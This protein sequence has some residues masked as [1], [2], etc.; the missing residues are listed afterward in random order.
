MKSESIIF[1]FFGRVFRYTI[2]IRETAKRKG[3]PM[4]NATFDFPLKAYVDGAWVDGG[5]GYGFVIL[6]RSSIIAE[7]SES[8][9]KGPWADSRQVGGEL[10]A[11]MAVL[12][13]CEE[14]SVPEIT[15]FYDYEGIRSWA[16]GE[17]K[18]NKEITRTYVGE[19]RRCS[20]KVRW[21]KVKSHS[22]DRYN[23]RVDR[24]AKDGAAGIAYYWVEE[25]HREADRG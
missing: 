10:L 2:T 11:M 4:E 20:V 8:V 7:R 13:W 9:P 14:R 17:W 6:D 16:V 5:V 21:V 18:A 25:T 3:M 19:M 1:R 12:A 23:D 22:G 24:L 15:V